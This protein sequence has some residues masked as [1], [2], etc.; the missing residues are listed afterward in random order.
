L[1][2]EKLAICRAHKN[3]I[4]RVPKPDYIQKCALQQHQDFL[5]DL[6]TPKTRHEIVTK[7]WA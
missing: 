3:Q 1:A 6:I 2:L 5:A 4:Q 7:I